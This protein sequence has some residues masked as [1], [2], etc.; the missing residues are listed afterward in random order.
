MKNSRR[1]TQILALATVGVWGTI[2]YQIYSASS[3]NEPVEA[4]SPSYFQSQKTTPFVYVA[5]V[6]DPFTMLALRD[7]TRH[8]N[9][10]DKAA[11]WTP[12]PLKVNGILEQKKKRTAIVEG[13]AGVVFMRERDTLLGVKILKIEKEKVV[14]W[15]RGQK[16]EWRIQ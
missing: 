5:D 15:Y 3:S 14:Y 11:P 7:T 6:R 2:G 10:I 16:N 9:R 8:R 13:P 12:P 1:L 4:A